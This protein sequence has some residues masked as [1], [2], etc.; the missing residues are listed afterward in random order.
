MAKPTKFVQAC[1]RIEA[2]IEVAT[3]RGTGSHKTRAAMTRDLALWATADYA[4]SVYPRLSKFKLPWKQWDKDLYWPGLLVAATLRLHALDGVSLARARSWVKV[5]DA[6]L[7]EAFRLIKN[8][9]LSLHD[10][11]REQNPEVA[12]MLRSSREA[13]QVCL[14]PRALEDMLLAAAEGY[15]VAPPG[16]GARYTEVFGLC[17]GSVRRRAGR[18][19]TKDVFVNV[20]R[21]ATQMRARA[22]ANA[23]EPNSKS[24]R[25]QL[26]VGDQFFPHLEVVGDYHTHPY[27]TLTQLKAASGWEYSSADED[28]LPHHIDEVRSHHHADPL[29]SLVVA[30][31]AGGKASKLSQRKAPNVVQ[32]SVG[33]LYFVIGAYRIALDGSYDRKVLLRVSAAVT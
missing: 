13:L 4:A 12:T 20:A 23:V 22:T 29:F 24:L 6:D 19:V 21:V 3:R 1:R 30:V 5:P 27:K 31:A 26:H 32:V 28:S 10:V 17:F 7:R 33:D 2:M 14:E 18:S 8:A 25:A 9:G 16:K 15:L 11:V